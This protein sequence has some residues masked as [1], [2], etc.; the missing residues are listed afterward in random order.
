[1]AY[2]ALCCPECKRE[3]NHSEVKVENLLSS[4]FSWLGIKPK[5]PPEGLRLECPHC[6]KS[7]V[8]VLK[9]LRY[10]P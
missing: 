7:S 4:P 6:K 3:F 2:W 1:M 5:F 10:S 8:F 9:Q